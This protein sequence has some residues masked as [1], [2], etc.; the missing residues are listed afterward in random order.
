MFLASDK[1][2]HI[3]ELKVRGQTK[4]ITVTPKRGITKP[5]EIL[6]DDSTGLGDASAAQT[7]HGN[8]GRRVWSVLSF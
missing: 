1:G 4:R 6:S 2:A 7:P 8:S 3:E 5:Y